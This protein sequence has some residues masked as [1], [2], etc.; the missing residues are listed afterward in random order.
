MSLS[1][2]L[3]APF[4]GLL[5]S[6]FAAGG[7]MVAVPLLSFGLGMPLKEAIAAS[8]VIV[9]CISLFALLQKKRWRLIDWRR[10]RFFAV[11]GIFGGLAGSLIGLRISDH[12]QALFFSML[13]LAV[14]WWMHSDRMQMTMSYAKSIPCHC[15]YA[16]LAGVFTGIITGLLGVGG[17]FLIVPLLLMLG[18]PNY[19]AA[20]A[21]SLLLI[22]SSSLVA[23]Y[24][25]IE[26]LNIQWDVILTL[27]VLAALGAW[28]GNLLADKFS[29]QRLQRMFSFVLSVMAGWMLIKTFGDLRL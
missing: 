13:L 9:A 1:L 14:A 20:V 18:V 27:G 28:V 16:V 19:Q 4:I 15:R 10:H 24:G 17:G 7:G 6:L 21:H 8:L 25:Y 11:G 26:Y 12:I 29:S 5:L 23:A 2:W 3:V 22:V